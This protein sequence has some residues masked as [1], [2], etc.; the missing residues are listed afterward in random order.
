MLKTSRWLSCAPS[1]TSEPCSGVRAGLHQ[2]FRRCARLPEKLAISSRQRSWSPNAVREA[3]TMA[4][5]SSGAPKACHSS[6]GLV[7]FSSA[8]L[9]SVRTRMF[10]CCLPSSAASV[11]AESIA[12]SG[13][14]HFHC[15]N[16]SS[17]SRQ[18]LRGRAEQ[19]RFRSGENQPRGRRRLAAEKFFQKI[20]RAGLRGNAVAHGAHGK[21][22]VQHDDERARGLRQFPMRPGG[23]GDEQQRAR[24]VREKTA[25]AVAAGGF[26]RRRIWIGREN[27]TARGWKPA[28]G[29]SG[30]AKYKS[31]R[32]PA[33]WPARSRRADK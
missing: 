3:L 15:G 1:E 26:L 21:G 9:W 28:G 33:R 31:P 13:D 17:T 12:A 16:S 14:Q 25:A 29:E 8:G 2:Q 6:R 27:A 11:M 4:K 24:A 22:I 18:F 10:A 5:L 7:I 32:A 20:F 23:G 19:T 30:S